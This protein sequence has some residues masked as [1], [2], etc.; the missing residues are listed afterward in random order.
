ML[1]GLLLLKILS[2]PPEFSASVEVIAAIETVTLQPAT[3]R[4]DFHR[5]DTLRNRDGSPHLARWRAA[6]GRATRP[7]SN[8]RCRC[9]WQETRTRGEHCCPAGLARPISGARSQPSTR[10]RRAA[11]LICLPRADRR[12]I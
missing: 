10:R 2:T 7:A 6:H 9:C 11:G 5:I 3:S 1:A 12:L 4:R 8:S